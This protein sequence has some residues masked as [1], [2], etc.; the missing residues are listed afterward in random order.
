MKLI[1]LLSLIMW[2]CAKKPPAPVVVDYTPPIGNTLV[3]EAEEVAPEPVGE[4]VFLVPSFPVIY[5]D[6]DRYFIRG[7]Q[8]H[9]LRLVIDRMPDGAE[10]TIEGHACEIGTEEYNDALGEQRAGNV[11]E[12]LSNAGVKSYLRVVSYGESRPATE[13]PDRQELNRR[14]QVN[15]K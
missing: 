1:I 11:A 4:P 12:W 7:D 8:L 10:C 2:G 15:C 13:D 14:V 5:F 9:K 6:L 3:F